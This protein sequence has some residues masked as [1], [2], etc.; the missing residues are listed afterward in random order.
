MRILITR[1]FTISNTYNVTVSPPIGALYITS[2]LRKHYPDYNIKFYDNVLPEKRNLKS[3]KKYIKKFKPDIIMFSSTYVERDIIFKWTKYSKKVSEKIITVC[4]G[5]GP[6]SSPGEY[7]KNSCIDFVVCGEG[8]ER[9]VNL[10][11]NIKS[12]Q[13]KF[14]DGICYKNGKECIISKPV[15]V[16]SQLDDITFPA[17]EEHNFNF[18]SKM[19]G[20]VAILKEIPYAYMMTSRGCPFNCKFCHNSFGNKIRSRSP[21]NIVEEIKLLKKLGVKTIY[22]GDDIFNLQTDKAKEICKKIIEANLDIYI[23]FTGIRIDFIDKELFKLIKKA[24]GYF[25]EFGVQ[26]ISPELNDS[27]KRNFNP[28]KYKKNVSYL[29][30]LGFITRSQFI[31]GFPGETRKQSLQNL[32]FALELDADFTSFFKLTPYP[33]TWYGKNFLKNE[34]FEK[35]PSE[36]FNF[37]NKNPELFMG[38]MNSSEFD[39]FLIEAHK[40]FYLRPSKILKLILKIPYNKK[41]VY[42]LII[43]FLILVLPEKLLKPVIK[44]YKNS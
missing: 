44:I 20:P 9:A 37:Y 26:H 28:K 7:I 34:T 39:E 10:I 27:G 25:L 11:E 33:G 31:F 2:T 22:F 16:V 6:N 1:V 14:M 13:K 12:K 3:F 24:G 17:W 32:K 18:Y 5:P 30:K 29:K 42:Q 35:I 8:E 36:D 19:H 21:E 38:N 41:N 40:K 23:G 4:G 43:K 15:S